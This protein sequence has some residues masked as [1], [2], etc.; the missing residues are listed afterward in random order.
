M[1]EV[2]NDFIKIEYDNST[3]ANIIERINSGGENGIFL[4]YIQRD[5]VWKQE[6]ICSLLDSLMRGY[7]IGDILIWETEYPVNYRKFERKY[8]SNTDN[9]DFTAGDDNNQVIKQYV[10][11]GQQRL[12]SLYIA[13]CGAY[14]NKILFFNLK[15]SPKD[16][17]DNKY[18]FT[19]KSAGFYRNN[20]NWLNV[21]DFLS[22]SF[23]SN[24]TIV[25]VL[26]EEGIIS[27][28]SSEKDR[29]L[30]SSNAQRLYNIFKKIRNVHIQVLT[31]NV[32][33]VD[34]AE[35]FVRTN[36]GGVVL[37]L[38]DLTMA[39]ITG[40][41]VASSKSFQQL[42]DKIKQLGFDKPK[43]FILQACN[44]ILTVLKLQDENTDGAAI[45]AKLSGNFIRISVSIVSVLQFISK[46]DVVRKFTY[47]SHNPIFIIIAYYYKHCI[48][49]RKT[50][51]DHISNVRTFLLISLLAKD[52]RRLNKDL[53]KDLLEYVTS[54][55]GKD[56]SLD[57]I[58]EIFNKK[59]YGKNFELNIDALLSIRMDSTI[60]PLVLYFIYYGQD[61]FKTDED[62]DEM[63]GMTV[64]DHIFPRSQLEKI[65]VFD[66]KSKKNKRKYSDDEVNSILNCELLTQK[67][68]EYSQDGKGATLP[69]DFF[70][71][72]KFFKDENET[73]RFI[74]LHAI[75][76]PE[77]NSE[78]NNIW[79][80]DNYKKFLIARKNL[81]KER[82][83]EKY[84][85]F[86]T[87]NTNDDNI[88]ADVKKFIKSLNQEKITTSLT[89]DD[90]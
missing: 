38:K 17:P 19:F 64:R 22:K 34:M 33:L 79:N 61:D 3:I 81:L 48:N 54:D 18:A 58:K 1:P 11:D 68:N 31:K 24:F 8:N 30:I 89:L 82:L 67:L 55:D 72:K 69:E 62:E 86:I 73:K 47:V 45:Q 13:M 63:D 4:P 21:P 2:N 70:Y 75:P 90:D 5:F 85:N 39:M 77:D 35:I 27:E 87:P 60:A 37:E 84:K 59:P 23:N 44:T 14:D 49:S 29:E 20:S 9:N 56:F 40:R 65:Y 43:E 83:I 41:W 32:S 71:N 46:I 6:R 57:R 53:I 28:K 42:I 80:I 51:T 52:C 7:P 50:W 12:Q 10:L 26:K 66:K 25:N 76:E 78:E 88:P 74:K 16:N 36:S 15:S